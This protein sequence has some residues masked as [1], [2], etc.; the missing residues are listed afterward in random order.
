LRTTPYCAEK[1][2]M[3]GLEEVRFPLLFEERDPTERARRPS[4]FTGDHSRVSS[5]QGGGAQIGKF[6]F[7]SIVSLAFSSE[8]QLKS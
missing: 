7:L 4:V 1:I 5:F 3:L 8:L 6:P 2:L